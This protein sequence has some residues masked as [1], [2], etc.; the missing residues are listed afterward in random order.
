[1]HTI[2]AGHPA[3]LIAYAYYRIGCRPRES[4]VLIGLLPNEPQRRA[5][6]GGRF[7]TGVVA[8]LDLP[9]V[10][11]RRA[12]FTHVMRLLAD[13][14]HEALVA[15]VIT[16]R[17]S[18]ALA[19]A[20]R[21]AGRAVGMPVID[22]IA[23]GA[24]SFRS[25]LCSDPSCCP[26][27][28]EPLDQVWHGSMAAELVLRGLTLADDARQVIADVLPGAEPELAALSGG[29]REPPVVARRVRLARLER[30]GALVAAQPSRT[31]G[32]DAP[33][34]E[35]DLI[36]LCRGLEDLR[37]RDAVLIAMSAPEG[38]DG[39]EAARL[40][41]SGEAEIALGGTDRRQPDEDLLA[42]SSRVLAAVARRAPRG[43]RAEAL[44]ALAWAAWWQGATLRSRLLAELALEDRPGHR[45]SE[46]VL[47]LLSAW[48][49][50]PWLAHREQFTS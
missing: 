7:V 45:L 41:A 25:M 43:R 24:D 14:G 27:E 30:W 48:V 9:P 29:D 16:E 1:M 2:T 8:R 26:E 40:M 34:E 18:A 46:L 23:V 39:L 32:R 28:G 6:G 13:H 11:A 47:G 49:A 35:T 37:L 38:A 5:A 20:V 44:G 50:P 33:I 19:R 4:L 3:D 17:P 12:E 36:E 10:R 31:D 21:Q 15:M 22:L 42:R